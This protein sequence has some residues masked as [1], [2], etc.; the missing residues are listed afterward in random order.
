[1][2]KTKA[3]YTNLPLDTHRELKVKLAK[4]GKTIQQFLAQ[5]VEE[6]LKEGK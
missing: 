4:D 6:Y 1:M 3:A 2:S 5:A